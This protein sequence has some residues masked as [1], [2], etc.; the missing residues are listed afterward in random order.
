MPYYPDS[1]K[2]KM[3][4][5]DTVSNIT[6]SVHAAE[7][8]GYAAP[9]LLST[10][11][12]VAG[13]AVLPLMLADFYLKGQKES[14]GKAGDINASSS[15]SNNKSWDQSKEEAKSDI[16]NSS[17]NKSIFNKGGKTV[18][19]YMTKLVNKYTNGGNVDL[20]PIPSLKAKKL[21]TPAVTSSGPDLQKRTA[22][23]TG[24]GDSSGDSSGIG[25]YASL[26]SAVGGEVSAMSDDNDATTYTGGEIAGD[27]L[28]YAAMGAAAG[29]IGAAVGAVVGVGIG[30]VKMHKAKKAAKKAE[31]KAEQEQI[32]NDLKEISQKKE[33]S[34]QEGKTYAQEKTAEAQKK[35]YGKYGLKMPNKYELG[36]SLDNP[37]LKEYAPSLQFNTG[38]M[39]KGK[40][41]HKINPLTVVD[42][43][44]KPT[45]MELTG[46]EGVYDK[47]AQKN[48]ENA[49]K[50]KNYAKA[51][52]IV[53]GEIQ[54]W[55]RRGMYK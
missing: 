3:Y 49:I 16:W 15:F 36:G 17:E 37:R 26:G 12:R 23:S 54:D 1:D 31:K 48:I 52:M 45:G 8:G 5:S 41:N 25:G 27:A 19:P 11:G 6:H 53:E 33:S 9:R 30:V 35:L 21:P 32:N 24:G 42:K 55:K 7:A 34:Y 4:S 10:V 29:P 22:P 44:G 2:S 13:R 18:N 14:G 46:G 39:T 51:G 28:K 38:G 40:Y 47:M 50:N 20:T 43:D